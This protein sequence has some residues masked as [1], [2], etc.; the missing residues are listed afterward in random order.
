MPSEAIIP[1]LTRIASA[2]DKQNEL[3][4]EQLELLAAIGLAVTEPPQPAPPPQPAR[5]VDEPPANS[6]RQR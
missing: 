3:L 2:L 1:V 4:E 5:V 6:R